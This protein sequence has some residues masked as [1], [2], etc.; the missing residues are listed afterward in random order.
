MGL[1]D[2]FN[3]EDR[4][5]VKFSDFYAMMKEG[6]RA[7]MMENGLKN[8]IPHAHILAVVNGKVEFATDNTEEA[9]EGGADNE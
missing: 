7:E 2:A 1:M 5:Q 6:T 4:V 8:R 9:T 3:T